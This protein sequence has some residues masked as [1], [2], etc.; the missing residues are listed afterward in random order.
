MNKL[1]LALG[2]SLQ[3]LTFAPAATP[4]DCGTL[5]GCRLVKRVFHVVVYADG[6][7]YSYWEC[8]YQCGN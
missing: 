5:P 2:L 6:Y 4:V 3:A 8:T 7:S 1:F